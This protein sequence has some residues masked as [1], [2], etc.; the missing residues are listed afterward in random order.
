[1]VISDHNVKSPIVLK[2]NTTRKQWISDH[3]DTSPIVPKS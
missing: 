2:D 3:T 1:M